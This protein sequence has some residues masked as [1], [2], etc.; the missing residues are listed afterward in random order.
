[1]WFFKHKTIILLVLIIILF[2]GVGYLLFTKVFN[3]Q[4]IAC[5]M[6]A[7]ICPDGSYVGRSGPDCE[8]TPC[9]EVIAHN[10]I[11]Y[12]NAGLGFSLEYPAALTAQY[13]STVSWPP[14]V[15]VSQADFICEETP[16]ES[17]LPAR[18]SHRLVDDRVYCVSANSEG[19]AGS[20][21]TEYTYRAV[22]DDKFV[23]LTFTL[24]YPECLNYDEPQKTE[25]Q[26]EREAFDLDGV[27][28]RIMRTVSFGG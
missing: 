5:T 3:N 6:E 22:I 17:S 19:A 9:S 14:K 10:W 12:E 21:Y 11:K 15:T 26:N 20:V 16:A 2:F 28:D 4:Q 25:C 24:R 8:F 18:V 1:M 27:A 13:I 7:K 23:S